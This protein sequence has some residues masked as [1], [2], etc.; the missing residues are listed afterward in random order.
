MVSVRAHKNIFC[1]FLLVA[2]WQHHRTVGLLFFALSLTD[3]ATSSASVSAS[4]CCSGLC[5][6]MLRVQADPFPGCGDALFFPSRSLPVRFYHRWM[7]RGRAGRQERRFSS[8]HLPSCL[9]LA[10]D[11]IDELHTSSS[12]SQPSGVS[13]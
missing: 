12:S 4:A 1:E 6:L 8:A 5:C 3:S 9:L 13:I 11:F 2:R 10:E 7:T